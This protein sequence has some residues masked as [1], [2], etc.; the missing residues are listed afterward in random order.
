MLASAPYF[1]KFGVEKHRKRKKLL[2]FKKNCE[3]IQKN[4]KNILQNRK[5]NSMILYK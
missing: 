3:F 1:K 2:I 5:K 4:S